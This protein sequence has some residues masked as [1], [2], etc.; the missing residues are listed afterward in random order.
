MSNIEKLVKLQMHW[1]KR[2]ELWLS[3]KRVSKRKQVTDFGGNPM[4]K[5]GFYKDC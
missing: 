4:K 1:S 3:S 2:S 5:R